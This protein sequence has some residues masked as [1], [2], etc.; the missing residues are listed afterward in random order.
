MLCSGKP[1]T[2]RHHGRVAVSGETGVHRHWNGRRET[3]SIRHCTG[4]ALQTI[5]RILWQLH[6]WDCG[7]GRRGCAI[8]IADWGVLTSR[9]ALGIP[10]STLA[11]SVCLGLYSFRF[12]FLPFC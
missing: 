3:C 9:R 8:S 7:R 5:C 1:W 6:C 4:R 2:P 10:E 12:L 11:F